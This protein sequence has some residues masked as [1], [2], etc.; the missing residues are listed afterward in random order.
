[1][2]VLRNIYILKHLLFV[3]EMQMELDMCVSSCVKLTTLAYR[4][5]VVNS[6][7]LKGFE[8][9]NTKGSLRTTERAEQET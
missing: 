1:M 6:Q 7:R 9:V 5:P 2:L 4:D 8:T 3:S